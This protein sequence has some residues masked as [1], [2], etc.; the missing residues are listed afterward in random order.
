[1]MLVGWVRTCSM[2]ALAQGTGMTGHPTL[3]LVRFQTSVLEMDAV[4]SIQLLITPIAAKV[5]KCP[6]TIVGCQIEAI[7]AECRAP[8]RHRPRLRST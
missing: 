7:L 2:H 3:N 8:L 5:F 6:S 1:M 4:A